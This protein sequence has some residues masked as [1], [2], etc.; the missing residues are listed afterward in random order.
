MKKVCLGLSGLL[1]LL[2]VVYATAAP[3]ETISFE[4]ATSK[5]GIP[6]GNG[7][8]AWGDLNGDDKVDLLCKNRLFL[9][10]G[11]KFQDITGPSGLKLK[12]HATVWG[13]FNNDGYPDI[14]ATGAKGSLWLNL[15]SG[16][17]KQVAIPENTHN[18]SKAAAWADVNNDGY[19]DLWVTN[20]EDST[21]YEQKGFRAQPDLLMMNSRGRSF[22]LEMT[23]PEE[24]TWH[25]RG[26]VFCDFDQDGD[27]DAFCS[28]YR[29]AP[30]QL[31]I[32]EKGK[33]ANK[34]KEYGV[35][36]TPSGQVGTAKQYQAHGHT[37]GACWADFDNDDD[38][39]L[40]VVNFSHAS[41]GQDHMQLFENLGE[42]G[43][44]KF[45]DV[46][47]K[48]NFEWQE[49]YAK[50]AVGDF[51]NDGLIDIYLSTVYD[52]DT[53][54]LYRN[55]GGF[56]FENV[57][58]KA[59]ISTRKS[60]QAAVADYDNDGFLD[61]LAGGMLYRNKG[62]KNSWL[63]VRLEAKKTCRKCSRSAV[64]AVVTVKADKLEVTR[65]V[66]A[67]NC[68]NQ[69]EMTLHFGLGEF[70]GKAKIEIRWPCG[71]KQTKTTSVNKLL[72]IKEG[73]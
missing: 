10:R 70:K 72:E 47:K 31:W 56:K 18:L 59:G 44:Y 36:G 19:L 52:R 4:D 42:K 54:R 11:S 68:G 32:N 20:Y 67:G 6:P 24:E 29:L 46:S 57:T 39:D 41:P 12:G 49:S 58:A 25:T 45:E 3:E 55:K 48:A 66:E 17:F 40:L 14:Y 16:R 50:G 69:N 2:C 43:K 23:T 8:A 73:R 34:A 60:Y 15:K 1:T 26:V 53:G 62:N 33:F 13:D 28:N 22:K 65:Q 38:F 61:L 37:I 35:A 27:M 30:N 9:N 7:P 63:K 71:R 5:A 21:N 51:D 64:G